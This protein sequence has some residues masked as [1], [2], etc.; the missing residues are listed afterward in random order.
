MNVAAAES[1]QPAKEILLPDV[2]RRGERHAGQLCQVRHDAV[3]AILLSIRA[4]QDY[5]HLPD[6]SADSSRIARASAR[7]AA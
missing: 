2:R 4:E 5:L 6:A 3:S 7:Y 1:R